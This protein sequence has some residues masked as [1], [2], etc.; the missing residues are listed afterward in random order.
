MAKPWS[1][2]LWRL[3]TVIFAAFFV[4]LVVGHPT[5]LIIAG[6]L[7][8][9][10]WHL[11]N[12]VRLEQWLRKGSREA[13]PEAA[14]IW[15]EIFY[16][17]H[18]FQ[19]TSRRRKRRLAGIVSRFREVTAAMPDAT[20]TISADG[21]IQWFNEAAGSLLGLKSSKDIGQRIHNL[22]R[23]PG[24]AAFLAAGDESKSMQMPSPMDD[25]ATLSLRVIPYGR[26]QRL[27]VARDI[28]Q[29]QRLDQMRRDFVAN[30]SHELRTPLT[31]IRGFLETMEEEEG[32]EC[33]GRWQRSIDLMQQ[34]VLRMQRIVED[35]LLLSRLETD[36]SRPQAP[37]D[38][39]ALAA[40][41]RDS[42][43]PLC[44]NKA[45]KLIMEWDDA[46]RIYGAE[47]ELNSAFGNLITNAVR[48]TPEGGTITVRWFADAT[49]AH[50]EVRDTGVGIEAHHIPRLTERF[51]R[52]DVGRS[53]DTGGTGLGLA[54]VKH[55][56]NRHNAQLRIESVPGKGSTFACDFPPSSIVRQ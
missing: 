9:S 21:E 8:Y 38:V 13:P 2:E 11:Y 20:V 25:N 43:E 12:L 46:L 26:E 31:V 18:R 27:L 23:H 28:S 1:T 32:D 55:V 53:R 49:G 17:L 41:L 16:L 47:Q 52:V 29:Q 6:F 30:V 50:F 37:V 39:P 14:G 22:L 5:A 7:G 42:V 3:A 48:Y 24:L 54:I 15:G 35:L 45:Q 40:F 44:R 10:A 51:Y 36:R 33:V 19:Q 4:G 56:L 34:Q